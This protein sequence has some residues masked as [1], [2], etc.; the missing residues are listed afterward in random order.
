MAS[1]EDER[2]KPY[3]VVS[4]RIGREYNEKFTKKTLEMILQELSSA[5][6]ENKDFSNLEAWTILKIRID[7]WVDFFKKDLHGN[8]IE[9]V[10]WIK[11]KK[12]QNGFLKQQATKYGIKIT[13]KFKI[14]L[15]E[16]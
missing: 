10:P 7:R 3:L 15:R 12:A 2:G 6:Q 4:Q 8:F 5:F 14:M 9:H 1:E 11:D 13:K 16:D